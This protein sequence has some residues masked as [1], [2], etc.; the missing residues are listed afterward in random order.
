MDSSTV[1][2]ERFMAIGMYI[3]KQNFNSRKY[4]ETNYYIPSS[5]ILEFPSVINFHIITSDD[6]NFH[7]HFLP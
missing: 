2:E 1:V 6:I 7:F 4:E 5:Q 3:S